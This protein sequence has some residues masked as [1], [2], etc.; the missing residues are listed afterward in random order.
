MS[1][2]PAQDLSA[3]LPSPSFPSAPLFSRPLRVLYDLAKG[4]QIIYLVCHESRT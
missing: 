2:S 3:G 1:H 4:R